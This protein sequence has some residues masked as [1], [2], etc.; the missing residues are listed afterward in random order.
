MILPI[1]NGKWAIRY[2]C[3]RFGT[4]KSDL[5]HRHIPIKMISNIEDI[6]SIAKCVELSAKEYLHKP[7]NPAMLRSRLGASVEKKRSDESLTVIL[8]SGVTSELKAIGEEQPRGY[9][10][11]GLLFVNIVGLTNCCSGRSTEEVTNG[12]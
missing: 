7:F 10:N 12:L 8:P 5:N 4:L 3:A 1:Q 9:E 6:E 2:G 11:I